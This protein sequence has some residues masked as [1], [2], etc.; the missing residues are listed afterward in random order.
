V[1][2]ALKGKRCFLKFIRKF[3]LSNGSHIALF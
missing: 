1:I 3:E 2:T